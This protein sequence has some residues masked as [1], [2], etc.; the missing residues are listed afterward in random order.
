MCYYL[1]PEAE[2]VQTGQGSI[3][4]APHLLARDS[5]V[6]RVGVVVEVL[7]IEQIYQRRS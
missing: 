5:L 3:P 1:F 2:A 4:E 6:L 7:H